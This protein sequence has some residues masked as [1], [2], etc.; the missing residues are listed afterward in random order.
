MS[1]VGVDRFF[2]ISQRGSSISQELVGGCLS[3][4]SI[5]YNLALTPQLLASAG[6]PVHDAVVA[7]CAVSALSTFMCGFFANLPFA[8]APR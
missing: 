8:V 1:C 6:V 2:D 3:F 4:I 7:T 5:L